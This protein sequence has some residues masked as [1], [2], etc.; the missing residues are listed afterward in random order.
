MEKR[1]TKTRDS[2]T[3]LARELGRILAPEQVFTEGPALRQGLQDGT[4]NR[5][6]I[7]TADALVEPQSTEETAAVLA[8]CYEN[9]VAIVPRGGGTGLAGGAVPSG[10]VVLSQARMN[11]VLSIDPELWRM[12]VESGVTTATVHRIALENG[13]LFPPDPGASEQSTIGGN[14]ATNAGGP[15]AFKYGVTGSWVTGVEAVV[16][17][18]EI[19]VSG[20]PVRKD[21]A[22]LD[23]THLMIGSEGTL[24]IVTSA[25][26]RLTPAPEARGVV[27][28]FYDDVRSGC[29]AVSTILAS[30]IQP[31]ALEYLDRGAL[32][33]SL[34]SFPF[35]SPADAGFAV[36]AEA[37]GHPGEVARVVGELEEAMARGAL[38]K[39][40]KIT[41]RAEASSVWSWRD[42]IS[43]AVTAQKGGKISED[44]VVPGEKLAE[45][46]EET[47]RIGERHGLEACSWGHAGDG[48]LHSTFLVD[49][50]NSDE[51]TRGANA[52]AEIFDMAIRLGG[53]ISGEH[54]IGSLKTSYVT[55]ALG[56]TSIRLQAEI[57]K[58]FDPKLLLN[59]G[60]KIL[61]P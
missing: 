37:D 10:G 7:G 48:N 31:T 35:E 28:A 34:G 54:G 41:D 11:R 59:P 33:S 25:W 21:V 38:G 46:I 32:A 23:L 56:E 51:M 8:W 44:V 40:L 15:H 30:G 57:K 24:G 60:K 13:L 42:G 9:D 3:A 53:S 2:A 27:V 58:V 26:L 20:G 14:I 29:E 18:G 52:A 45:A 16:P 1:P 5:G 50:N 6:V 43:I 39:A 47:V 4:G 49:L 19:L 61:L 36:L 22:G 55:K 17:P 12:E